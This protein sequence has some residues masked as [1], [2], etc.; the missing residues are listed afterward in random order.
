MSFAIQV[1]NSLLDI[2]SQMA[3]HPED[4]SKHPETDFIRT[5]KLDFFSLLYLIIVNA[6]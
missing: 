3:S 5:R 1:K 6:Q 2:I 4:F